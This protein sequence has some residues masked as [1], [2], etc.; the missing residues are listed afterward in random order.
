MYR[1]IYAYL[2]NSTKQSLNKGSLR[3]CY[4][5]YIN[6]VLFGVVTPATISHPFHLEKGG[7]RRN[8]P[9][10]GEEATSLVVTTVGGHLTSSNY[11]R[12]PPH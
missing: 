2:F 1:L 11:Y 4:K 3:K 8:G 10:K 7:D 6:K 5:R 9:I 12:R